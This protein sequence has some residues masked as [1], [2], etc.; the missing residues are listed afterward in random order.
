MGRRGVMG[1]SDVQVE[2]GGGGCKVSR[3]VGSEMCRCEVVRC[4][5]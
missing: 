3:W 4:E 5:T 1:R 2:V